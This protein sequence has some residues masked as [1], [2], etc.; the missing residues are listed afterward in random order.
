MAHDDLLKSAT[1]FILGKLS[2][3]FGQLLLVL[4]S[5]QGRVREKTISDEMSL[6]LLV[7]TASTNILPICISSTCYYFLSLTC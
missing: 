2:C 5:D 4:Q 3:Q 7:Q 6:L 1:G